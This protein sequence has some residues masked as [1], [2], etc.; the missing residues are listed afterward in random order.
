MVGGASRAE[1]AIVLLDALH[2]LAEQSKRH[3][4]ILS[5]FGISHVLVAVNKMDLV[6]YSEARFDAVVDECEAYAAKLALKDLVFVPVSALRGDNVVSRSSA[7][8]WYQ[9]TTVAYFLDHANLTAEENLVDLR[10]PVQSALPA[11]RQAAAGTAAGKTDETPRETVGEEAGEQTGKRTAGRVTGVCGRLASGILRR[12]DELL[13]LPRFET[14]VVDSITVGSP[15]TGGDALEEAQAGRWVM[16]G[17]D[18]AIAVER[19][20]LLVRPHNLPHRSDVIDATLVVLARETT[21][22]AGQPVLLQCGPDRVEA[23][24]DEIRY[25]LDVSG[26][27]RQATPVLHTNQIGRGLLSL[28]RPRWLDTVRRNRRGGSFLLLEPG[29]LEVAAAGFIRDL[30]E[31]HGQA[32]GCVVWLTGLPASG[33]STIARAVADHLSEFGINAIHLDGDVFRTFVSDDLGFSAEDR[34]ENVRRAAG[35]AALLSTAG[36]LVLVSFV[37]PFR[38]DR[39]TAKERI[40]AQRFLEV[41]V[42]SDVETCRR[43][44]PKGL[45][46]RAHRGEITGFTGVDGPYEAPISPDVVVDTEE[47]SVSQSADRIVD[48]LRKRGALSRPAPKTP[49]SEDLLPGHRDPL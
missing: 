41:Y 18:R 6:E 29:S 13:A 11:S 17:F 30:R 9:G 47:L 10:L 48:A 34:R 32:T 19:G 25:Q 37:S 16:V 15:A 31:L 2:G 4:L 42:R 49:A 28:R 14:A 22:T 40:G 5:L 35:T 46:A 8:P 12:G 26:L 45:Y 27:H 3:L 23:T 38:D 24:I 21:L 44:D 7:M 39:A 1:V 43:R 33:K 36:H 20:D